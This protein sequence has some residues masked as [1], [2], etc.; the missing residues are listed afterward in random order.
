MRAKT[1]IATNDDA[2][3]Q[4]VTAATWWLYLL[5]CTDGRTY[6]GVT[7][8]V[9]ARF[10]AHADGK[11]AKFTR[12]NPPLTVLG[13]QSFPDKST[14]LRAEYALKQLGYAVAI[15]LATTG[16]ARTA[17]PTLAQQQPQSMRS[18]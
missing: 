12:S 11:G 9:T 4:P 18:T 15:R 2:C 3:E 5:S 7:L 13:A 16:S 10:R 6:V 1:N 17:P 14:A 8:D